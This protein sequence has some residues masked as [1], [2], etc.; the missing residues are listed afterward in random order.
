MK[1]L[2]FAAMLCAVLFSCTKEQPTAKIYPKVQVRVI[3]NFTDG[4]QAISLIAH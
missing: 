2:L 1:K 4:S 3:T